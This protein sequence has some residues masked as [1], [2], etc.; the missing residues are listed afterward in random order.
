MTTP[1]SLVLAVVALATLTGCLRGFAPAPLGTALD[2]VCNPMNGELPDRGSVFQLGPAVVAVPKGWSAFRSSPQDL[3]L[4]RLDTELNVWY[5]G[6]FVFP[7]AEPQNAIRC[8]IA[9][10][11]TVIS[12]QATRLNTFSYRVDAGWAPPIEG[13][14]FYMQLQT[15][16]ASQLKAMRGMIEAVRF[17]SSDTLHGARVKAPGEGR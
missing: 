1:R 4:T 3:Q 5:G 7:A 14:H 12:I 2:A 13:Q 15:R 9:R 11:D 16:Y 6:R 8:T 17:V 10:G